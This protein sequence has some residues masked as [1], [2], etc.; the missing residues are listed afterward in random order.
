MTTTT[1]NHRQ[2]QAAPR[3]VGARYPVLVVGV[4]LA[5]FYSWLGSRWSVGMTFGGTDQNGEWV[6]SAGRRLAEPPLSVS[7]YGEPSWWVLAVMV[8]L[9]AGTVLMVR[10]AR[11]SGR[12]TR[13]WTLSGS[14]ALVV[15]TVGVV[16][17]F[18][19]HQSAQ[20]MDA[21]QQGVTDP[22]IIGHARVETSRAP[23]QGVGTGLP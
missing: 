12:P 7:V 21:F 14:M 9:T 3:S 22:P 13:W 19:V 17:V 23:D 18:N 1:Q 15:V 16:A 2:Q 5:G 4:V 20:I 10:R 11:A 8:A 6:D